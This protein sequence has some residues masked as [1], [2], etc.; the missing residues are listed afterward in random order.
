MNAV[1]RSVLA[2]L[3][4]SACAHIEQ[5]ALSVS[6]IQVLVK[7]SKQ[8]YV[9]ELSREIVVFD[10]VAV[11]LGLP[12]RNYLNVEQTVKG[13]AILDLGAGVGVLS[14]IAL[15]NGAA[16]SVATDINQ[17]AI[18]NAVYN[19]EQLGFKDKEHSIYS[20]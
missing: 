1:L 2:C 5:P 9:E 10:N 18:T 7:N 15:K 17:Y 11:G 13:K 20:Y 6:E 19:A 4:V 3:S 8:H 16:S 12:L 14:L